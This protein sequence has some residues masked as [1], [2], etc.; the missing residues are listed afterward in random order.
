[1]PLLYAS[2]LCQKLT[3][4]YM[5]SDNKKYWITLQQSM[6]NW[7]VVMHLLATFPDVKMTQYSIKF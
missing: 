6:F 2:A 4:G 1:M 7:L 3:Y 5:V